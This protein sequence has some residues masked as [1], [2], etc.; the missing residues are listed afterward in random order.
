[1]MARLRAAVIVMLV[2][3]VRAH[4]DPETRFEP[5]SQVEA[6]QARYERGKKL[7]QAKQYAA[8][9]DEFAAAYDLDQQAKFLLFN[10][11]VARRMAGSCRSAI[12]AYRAFLAA[13]PPTKL[14]E[15]AQIGIER[16]EKIVASLP[17]APPEPPKVEVEA[18]PETPAETQPPPPMITP[19]PPPPPHYVD[20]PAEP[21]YRDRIGDVL[22][23][24]G[25]AVA[26]ASATLYVLARGDADATHHPV[27]LADFE[28]DRTAA[29]QLQTA[30]AITGAASAVLVI[31]GVV[32]YST[33][34]RP[35][36]LVVAP[37]SQGV[38]LAIGGAF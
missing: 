1:M 24:S 22:T 26:L 11:G 27:S 23:G 16:C 28:S 18:K 36:H 34:S 21:W 12:D 6:A 5:P 33:R 4:A 25:A 37:A 30:S 8:A 32:H 9:A 20:G 38:G 10:L 14:G 35:R 13:D 17:P 2:L 29:S 31:S 7:F 15:N 19:A 3:R